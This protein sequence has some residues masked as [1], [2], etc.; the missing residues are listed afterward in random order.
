VTQL[1]FELETAA[2]NVEVMVGGGV[3]SGDTTHL[4]RTTP[5]SQT[6]GH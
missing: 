2:T 3:K 5:A 4:T 1:Q 6:T